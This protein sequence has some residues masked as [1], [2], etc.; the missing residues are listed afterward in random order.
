MSTGRLT[1]E[2]PRF[3]TN[4]SAFGI[5]VYRF[6]LTLFVWI[7]VHY[8][9]AEKRFGMLREPQHERKIFNDHRAP[10]FVLSFVEGLREIFSTLLD[11]QKKIRLDEEN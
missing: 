8:Q 9:V 10:P 7:L 6:N 3:A 1:A 5:A 4:V 11:G 2:N